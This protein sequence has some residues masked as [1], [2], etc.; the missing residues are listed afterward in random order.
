MTAMCSVCRRQFQEHHILLEMRG[1]TIM[2]F[3]YQIKKRCF[4]RTVG[5]HFNPAATRIGFQPG[6]DFFQYRIA[7]HFQRP[8][9]L[10][11]GNINADI[12]N[13]FIIFQQQGNF[14]KERLT[15]VTG[16]LNF[17]HRNRLSCSWQHQCHCHKHMKNQ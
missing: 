12:G 11:S 13:Y 15:Q 7:V 14:C 4:N 16:N 8:I 6:L 9:V 10:S 3:Q 2:D 17:T 5:I 1:M